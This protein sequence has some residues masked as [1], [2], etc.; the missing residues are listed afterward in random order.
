MISNNYSNRLFGRTRGRS[1]KKIDLKGVQI[2]TQKEIYD[3]VLEE[4]ANNG[5]SFID[6]LI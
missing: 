5:I 1:N 3:P 6:E 4:L 2:P